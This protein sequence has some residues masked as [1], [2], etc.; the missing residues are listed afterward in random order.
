MKKEGVATPLRRLDGL[1]NVRCWLLNVEP[2]RSHSPRAFP[3]SVVGRGGYFPGPKDS[4]THQ[5]LGALNR[6][7]LMFDVSTRSLERETRHSREWR[8]TRSLPHRRNVAATLD[9]RL[10]FDC[11][12]SDSVKLVR[13]RWPR[14]QVPADR[15][16]SVGP[17]RKIV[18]I[19]PVD[20]V[21]AALEITIG[22]RHCVI[23]R[24]D[25]IGCRGAAR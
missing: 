2:C 8:P 11:L 6:L 12:A 22:H 7:H 13:P 17:Y 21:R 14:L 25:K 1:L 20:Q 23:E 16:V 10:S 15:S 24:E 19:C 5:A 18:A 4:E 3:R 9:F